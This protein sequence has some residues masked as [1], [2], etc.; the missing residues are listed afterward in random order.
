ME[1]VWVFFSNFKI[2]LWVLFV[3]LQVHSSNK[4]KA[5]SVWVGTPGGTQHYKSGG[6]LLKG[7]ANHFKDLCHS[8]IRDG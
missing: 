7:I 4:L 3:V 2:R 6:T 5:D 8:L 1:K